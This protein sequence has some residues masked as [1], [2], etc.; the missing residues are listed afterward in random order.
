MSAETAAECDAFTRYLIGQPADDY[1]RATYA[2]GLEALQVP[3]N[4]F[5]RLL[6]RWVAGPAFFGRGADFYGRIFRPSGELRKKLV[7]LLAILESYGGTAAVTDTSPGSAGFVP[8]AGSMLVQG[9][10]SVLALFVTLP[11]LM[12]LHLVLGT[13][14]SP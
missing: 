9:T 8:F 5:D 6:C 3:T 13:R 4:R 2:R 12:P 11:V 1:V 14:E 7:L 10:L